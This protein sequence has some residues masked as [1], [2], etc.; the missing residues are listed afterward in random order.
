MIF[1]MAHRLAE[2]RLNDKKIRL[3]PYLVDE[4]DVPG[5]VKQMA[6]KAAEVSKIDVAGVDVIKDKETGLWYCL[7]VNENPQL[8]TG[9]FVD[10]KILAF[11]DYLSNQM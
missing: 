1:F 4:Q 11:S 9:A 2:P 6:I 3:K 10:K 8:V 5:A 7:E